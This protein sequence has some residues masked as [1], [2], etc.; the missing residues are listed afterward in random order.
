[1]SAASASAAASASGAAANSGTLQLPGWPA[2]PEPEGPLFPLGGALLLLAL[3]AAAAAAWWFGP[4][5]RAGRGRVA[6]WPM[7]RERGTELGDPDVVFARRLDAHHRLY[8]VRW[9]GA[10]LLLGV[11][12]QSAPTVLDRRPSA[13]DGGQP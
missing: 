13:T 5:R 11:G 8:V 9:R 10:E 1:M 2:R 7:P 6:V 4:R 12:P 3:M